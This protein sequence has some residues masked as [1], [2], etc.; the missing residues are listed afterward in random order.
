MNITIQGLHTLYSLPHQEQDSHNVQHTLGNDKI[1]HHSRKP[2][3]QTKL[4]TLRNRQENN[5][6][7]TQCTMDIVS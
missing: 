1:T 6:V 4:G 2:R 3:K 5:R 7:W